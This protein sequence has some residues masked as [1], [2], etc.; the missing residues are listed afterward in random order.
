LTVM[1][2]IGEEAAYIDGMGGLNA[3]ALQ[4]ARRDGEQTNWFELT[5]E[6]RRQANATARERGLRSL[7]AEAGFEQKDVQDAVVAFVNEQDQAR[8][9][10]RD[11]AAKLMDTVT[12]AATG[13]A[14]VPGL[15]AE[16]RKNVAAEKERRKAAETALDAKINYSKQPRL[17]A[18]LTVLGIIGDEAVS[19]ESG[20]A[21]SSVMMRRQNG[22]GGMGNWGSAAM[23]PVIERFQKMTPEQRRQMFD[24]FRKQFDGNAN[25]K[26][27][28]TERAEGH[29]RMMKRFDRNG[30][31]RLDPDEMMRV[32]DSF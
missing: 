3:I 32:M 13:D 9:P 11:Q 21:F 30:N 28:R 4:R 22:W 24:S 16:L 10:L 29:D 26:V 1:G 6:E 12:G 23:R 27:D 15:L 17:E 8:E 19:L 20:N 7:L 18:I 5:P 14:L 25:G 2:F 31:G